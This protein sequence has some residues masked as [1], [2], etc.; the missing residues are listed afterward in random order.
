MEHDGYDRFIYTASS[1]SI[2]SSVHWYLQ[3]WTTWNRNVHMWAT[4]IHIWGQ[5]NSYCFVL[6]M[7]CEA[8]V[9]DSGCLSGFEQE[10]EPRSLIKQFISMLLLFLFQNKFCV[11]DWSPCRSWFSKYPPVISWAFRFYLNQ[12]SSAGTGDTACFKLALPYLH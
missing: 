8:L 4:D 9:G 3:G 5:T 11:M 2:I 1:L 7:T 12:S 6:N 10:G